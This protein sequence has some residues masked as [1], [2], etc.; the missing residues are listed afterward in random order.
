MANLD[1]GIKVDNASALQSLNRVDEAI[2]DVGQTAQQSSTRTNK[3]FKTIGESI[4]SVGKNVSSVT[5]AIKTK[6]ISVAQSAQSTANKISAPY[7]KAFK[8]VSDASAKMTTKVKASFDKI[9]SL[10]G[11][12]LGI[13]TAIGGFFGLSAIGDAFKELQTIG[14]QMYKVNQQFGI[15][16]KTLETLRVAGVKSGVGFDEIADSLKDLKNNMGDAIL[17]GGEMAENFK[18]LGVSLTS[19]TEPAIKS[20]LEALAKLSDMGRSE[21]AMRMGVQIFGES[22]VKTFQGMTSDG[23]IPFQNAWKAFEKESIF[24]EQR[25]KQA[26]SFQL[27]MG[28]LKLD[29]QSWAM[30]VLPELQKKF[31]GIM[32]IFKGMGINLKAGGIGK[33]IDTIIFKVFDLSNA[34]IGVVG[35]VREKWAGLTSIFKSGGILKVFDYIKY[36]I[37]ASVLDT[38]DT[39]RIVLARTFSEASFSTT[40]AI[41][42]NIFI[43]LSSGLTQAGNDLNDYIKNAK[44]ITSQIEKE[45]NVSEAILGVRK[46]T[47]K[48]EKMIADARQRYISGQ[49]KVTGGNVKVKTPA[50]QAK[51]DSDRY[52][53]ELMNKYAYAISM[54]QSDA[55]KF[56]AMGTTYGNSFMSGLG[57][58]FRNTD[59]LVAILDEGAEGGVSK[60]STKAFRTGLQAGAQKQMADA[61]EP[62]KSLTSL[63]FGDDPDAQLSGMISF[64]QQ[65][66]GQVQSMTD[67]IFQI[68]QNARDK[69]AEATLKARQEEITNMNI[70]DRRKAKLAKQAEKEAE[71]IRRDSFEKKKKYDTAQALINGASATAGAWASAM[72]LPFPANIAV[73]VAN[74][75]LITGVTIAQVAAIKSQEYYANGGIVGGAKGASMGPDNKQVNVRDG[76]MILNGIQQKRLFNAIDGG[77]IGSNGSFSPSIYTGDIIVQGNASQ[78]T[79]EDIKAI[80]DKQTKDLKRELYNLYV[81]NEIDFIK[82]GR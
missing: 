15:S 55:D 19:G 2:I 80:K 53:N 43:G 41:G 75:A 22:F 79:I 66:I 25:V 37:I 36:R 49:A 69:E 78:Q 30:D 7:I 23:L 58:S 13:A 72:Q 9:K 70:S 45:S 17:N 64:S 56:R 67:S 8:A 14:E 65:A 31:S 52:K 32:E 39:I 26:K 48:Y 1:I 77:T 82:R 50:D 76:E 62:K 24:N 6:F 20:T 5:S 18:K 40:N 27:F 60:I 74:S 59:K 21:E 3:A 10:A 81:N 33:T 63:I 16:I 42:K 4:Q 35:K 29:F 12:P 68:R 71:N 34:I 54:L 47:A 61:R 51:A 44:E 46:E 73:G 28:D 57:D 38:V 11:G